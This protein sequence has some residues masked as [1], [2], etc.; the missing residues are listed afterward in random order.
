MTDS[1]IRSDIVQIG[2]EI[3]ESPVQHLTDLLE[4]IQTN[5]RTA[6]SGVD[7]ITRELERMR[8]EIR[9]IT[10]SS[11]NI[12]DG[13]DD[14][15][16]EA[17]DTRSEIEDVTE[18]VEDTTAAVDE[19]EDKFAG[20]KDMAGKL[21]G[22]FAAAA[23]AFGVGTIISSVTE[24]QQAMNRFQ[25]QTG[26]TTA[27]MEG[28]QASIENL[29]T[30]AMGESIADVSDSMALVK[31]TTGMVGDELENTTYNALLMR[32]TFDFEV[33]ES[34]RA[35]DMMMSQFGVTSDEAYSM[36]AEGAQNGLNKNDDLL[37]TIN[38][39][40]VHFKQLGFDSEDMFNMLVNGAQN[41]TFSVDKLGDAV[42]EFGI[43]VVDGSE[44]TSEGFATIGLDATEMAR[45][46]KEGGESG[47]E[48][49]AETIEGL[50]A[51]EDPLARDA[52]GVA[53]FGTM[54][55]DLG[56]EGV[57]ALS[58]VTGEIEQTT[59]ALEGI[60]EVRYQ[61]LGSALEALKR[62]ASVLMQKAFT[63]LVNKLI[64]LINKFQEWGTK[65]GLV[66]KIKKAFDGI[67]TALSPI[68]AS[69]GTVI[70]KIYEFASSEKTIN[71]VKNAFQ[72]VKEIAEPIVSII[73][74]VIDEIVML[75]THNTTVT[76]LKDE[77]QKAKD[78]LTAIY[79]A[80][81]TAFD[82]IAENIEYILP[83]VEGLVAAFLLY[84]AAI[85]TVTIVVKL[86]TVAQAIYN[87]VMMASPITWIILGIGL[88]IGVIILLV[89]N[90]DKVKEVMQK[91]WDKIKSVWSSVG[92]WFKTNVVDPIV[93]FFTG[94]W[95]KIKGLFTTVVEFVK[96]NWKQLL[97]FIMNPLAGLF[98]LLY[99]N[100]DGFREKVN[101]VIEAI[102]TFFVGLWNKIVEIFSGVAG[103]FGEQF[104]EAV[105]KIKLVFGV[106]VGFFSGLWEDIKEMFTKIGT[107]VGN[108]IGDAFATVVNSIIGFAEKT[109]NKFIRNVNTAIGI[110]NAIPG[111]EIPL[112]TELDIPRLAKGGVVDK[113]TFAQIGED[114]K[115]AV[116]P[117]EN[118]LG[119]IKKVI[120]G[121]A[122]SIKSNSGSLSS[123]SESETVNSSVTERT[124]YNTYSPQFVLNMN[125]ASAT[126]DN[127]RKVKQWIKEA[128]NEMFD[129]LE[130]ENR[131][132]QEV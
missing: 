84:K 9:E 22:A 58:N 29:Y 89:K 21:A 52:A 34:I 41:G 102:K 98:A 6:T 86:I 47:K 60:N 82:F 75:A 130:N 107:T 104:S 44:T 14:M 96:N 73:Q 95:E 35:V 76:Y 67:K 27:S 36:I 77:F 91:V 129:N 87:A 122:D 62:K 38:E 131:P 49:F 85:L 93:N 20:L 88:L 120:G 59:E 10:R 105:E 53:L 54:W 112:I 125:G 2:F 11:S 51:M 57:F 39:Y 126:D 12:G 43:R 40:S 55:E 92:N 61:D 97:L 70:S 110:I 23:V 24:A 64:E 48:A 90:W 123:R 45:K 108:A 128:M 106:V 31:Q 37:D 1:V 132:V 16:R 74:S 8:D 113:P 121:V 69:I 7:S 5:A 78:E 4:G 26:V 32:D 19:C 65:V 118:N 79:D 33:S 46:F 17:R 18:E 66:D 119:W 94:L 3:D 42:K 80:A 71:T 72:K 30:Q 100:C 28:Y 63:P 15:G 13:I 103:W 56:A 68:V 114:G 99:N 50:K 101:E 124:E 25:A 115:E 111:V 117:L 116:V 109:I 81:K 127:K 83:L